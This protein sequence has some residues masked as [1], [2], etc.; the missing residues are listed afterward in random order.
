MKNSTT[1]KTILTV[2]AIFISGFLPAQN[3]VNRET[4]IMVK[5]G[6]S[7]HLHNYLGDSV[8]TDTLYYPPRF[9]NAGDIYFNGNVRNIS[10]KGLFL[11]PGGRVYFEGDALQTLEGDSLNFSTVYINN[12]GKG[13]KMLSPVFLTDTIELQDGSVYLDTNTLYLNSLAQGAWEEN[14]GYLVGEN[15]NYQVTGE[16]G[17][18]M[19]TREINGST[20]DEDI[21]GMGIYI[22][23]S[24]KGGSKSF[25][26][27]DIIRGH[28][29]LEHPADG[30]INKYFDIDPVEGTTASIKIRYNDS[31]DFY[32]INGNE[33]GKFKLWYSTTS[34]LY[35]FNKIWDSETDTIN[36]KSYMTKTLMIPERTT[37]F[38][39]ADEDCI[40][41]PHPT[42]PDIIY[43]CQGAS[44]DLDPDTNDQYAGYD[45]SWYK[46]GNADTLSTDPVY[47]VNKPGT[48]VVLVVSGKGC[49][50]YDTVEVVEAPLP[51]PQF[52]M[53]NFSCNYDSVL[54]NN[55]STINSGKIVNYCWQF[56]DTY[57]LT[58]T[59]K[60]NVKHQYTASALY[61]VILTATSNYGCDASTSKNISIFPNPI[62]DFNLS[63][64]CPDDALIINNNNTFEASTLSG[65][66]VQNEYWHIGNDFDTA[67]L[68]NIPDYFEVNR[69]P[70]RTYDIYMVCSSNTQCSDTSAT[71]QITVYNKPVADFTANNACQDGVVSFIP[72]NTVNIVGYE[73]QFGDGEGS[74]EQNPVHTYENAGVYVARL[75][76]FS[77]DLCSDT[78]YRQVRIYPKPTVNFGFDNVCANQI[79]FFENLV[80]AVDSVVFYNW[81][82]GDGTSS[83]DFAPFKLYSAA[84]SYQVKLVCTS[85]HGCKDSLQKTLTIYPLPTAQFNHSTFPCLGE[86][87]SFYN[88]S[89]V[90]SGT[91]TSYW[92][93]DDGTFSNLKNPEHTYLA[94]GDYNVSLQV[95]SNNGCQ[96]MAQ[97]MVTVYDAPLVDLGGAQSTCG[98]SYILDAGNPGCSYYW[99][100]G[101]TSQQITV[102]QSGAYSVVVTNSNGC[103]D[104]DAATITL[105]DEVNPQLGNDTN[106][107]S[108]LVL[109][110]GYQGALSYQ[111][112]P[113]G[114]G[115]YLTVTQTGLYAVTV[116]DQN[117]CVGSDSIY[118]IVN[119]PTQFT[120]GNDITECEGAEVVLDPGLTGGSFFWSDNSTGQT[121]SVNTSGLYWLEYTNEDECISYD[122]V[123]VNFL[124]NPAPCFSGDTTV[125]DYTVLNAGNS[126]CTYLWDNGSASQTMYIEQSGLHYVQ[127][128]NA[129]NCSITDSVY[130]TVN[131][132]YPFSLGDDTTLCSGNTIVLDAG[133]GAE[134]YLWSDGS[135]QSTLEAGASSTYW[136]V[137]TAENGCESSDSVNV[138]FSP[139]P[140]IRL[141]N[142]N[143]VC[144]NE[145]VELDAGNPGSS[146]IWGSDNG[147]YNTT[148][149]VIVDQQGTYWVDVVNTYGCAASDTV[150]IEK[151]DYSVYAQFLAASNVEIGEE[152][153]F[154]DVSYP[155]VVTW[156]W[157]FK[158]GAPLC[159][160]QHPYHT[161]YIPGIYNVELT[162]TN[163]ICTDVISKPITIFDPYGGRQQQEDSIFIAQNSLIEILSSKLYPNPNTGTFR[164]EVE[165]SKPVRAIV[166]IFDLYG[167]LVYK[168]TMPETEYLTKEFYFNHLPKGTYI[169]KAYAQTIEET[170]KIIKM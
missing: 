74:T 36:N 134:T 37:R 160:E 21:G 107:C 136:V 156:Q 100:T 119:Q 28:K 123:W 112:L 90:S 10:G 116:T 153:H 124:E 59:A 98:G 138:T 111:W 127:I 78:A 24:A 34:H 169:L 33:E 84:G 141:D 95:T 27:T 145:T 85:I 56:G 155:D 42:L 53:K 77:A 68:S 139:L 22:S 115:R 5:D 96:A 20:P 6:S 48:Y 7:L 121:L 45:I 126:G 83:N 72:Q 142:Y 54:F 23:H 93:F 105:N 86:S 144:S 149:T 125:C 76:V 146:Y 40:D 159:T 43:L 44:V 73:W 154:F 17:Y 163:S 57:L 130:V 92:E 165:F 63:N 94:P 97:D 151:T 143:I 122:S 164:Y 46:A 108:S 120:L 114:S 170:Y 157:N 89:S 1:C 66:W 3:M 166:M 91:Y 38:T 25:G 41:V 47:S 118:V 135:N 29:Q 18:I 14:Y 88:T 117:N 129:A 110:A 62:A 158:D 133:E 35:N 61:T 152:I 148:Q 104:S 137:A 106:V 167:R 65:Y 70:S 80:P 87:I 128:T 55:Q 150:I 19:V 82:F 140:I 147:Y 4:L 50:N 161:Y 131:E 2:L 162:V 11:N 30:S 81:S 26:E 71:K 99:N 58:D 113:A 103:F 49:F 79:V 39:I 13:V 12:N 32:N 64:A 67:F 15:N 52:T 75:V 8:N 31:V 168:S 69:L 102:T 9:L 16:N 60:S 109:D 101:A 51:E 132:S